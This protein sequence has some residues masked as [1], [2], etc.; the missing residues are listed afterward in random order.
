MPPRWIIKPADQD[1]I[2]GNAVVI[3]CQADGFP[4]PTVQW[5][6]SIGKLYPILADC[7]NFAAKSETI[8]M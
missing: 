6:Q 1:A 5:K 3:R 2:L 4:V 7:Q 8:A